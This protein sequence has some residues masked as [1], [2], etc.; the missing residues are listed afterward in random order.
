MNY[1]LQLTTAIGALSALAMAM[2]SLAQE[3]Y[4]EIIVTAQKKSES[5]QSV[6]ISVT[7]FSG[8]DIREGGITT[9]VGIA[10]QTP[11][12]NIGTPVGEGNNPSITLRGIGLN[13]F[14]DNNEGPVSVYNDGVYVAALPAQTFQLFDL[15]RVEVL[16]GPQG[17]LFGRNA[18]GGLIQFV[19]KKPT[20]EFE[21]FTSIT[22]GSFSQLK[23]ESAIG[24]SILDGVQGRLS[25]ASNRQDAY[26]ENTLGS[27]GNESDNFAARGQLNFDIK[28]RGSILLRGDYAQND[29]SAGR[30]AQEP[31]GSFFNEVFPDQLV[32]QFGFADTDG[33]PFTVTQDRAG[34]E[35]EVETYTFSGTVDY[36]L[37]D[38]ISITSITSYSETD[39]LYEEDTDA[40]PT[41]GINAD[42]DSSSDQFSQE[43]RFSGDHGKFSWQGGGFY[44]NSTVTNDQSVVVNQTLEF[45]DFLDDLPGADGGFE[46][47][48]SGLL[49][50]GTPFID[51]GLF[52]FGGAQFIDPSRNPIAVD[53]SLVNVPI[54]GDF[55]PFITFDV[56]YEQDTESFA[57]FYQFDYDFTDDLTLT[58]GIR[59]TN[60]SRDIQ[61]LNAAPAGPLLNDFFA[62]PGLVDDT[63]PDLSL[64]EAFGSTAGNFFDFTDEG[65]AARGLDTDLN[66]IDDD[67]VTGRAVIEYQA[68][69]TSL[70]YASYNRGFK[71]AGFNT[72]FLDSS[73]GVTVDQVVYD[74]ETL[75]AY[76]FGVKNTFFDGRFRLNAS[77]F[78]YDY[79]DFQA[80]TFQGLS[81]FITN[82]DATFFG[83]EVE[84]SAYLA[85]G[86]EA[87]LGISLLDTDVD[88][89]QDNNAGTVINDVEAV[90]A[91]NFSIN[92][93][94]SYEKPAFGGKL[95]GTVDFSYQGS[96]FFDI[97][98]SD[99]SNEDAYGLVNLR[100]AY[101]VGDNDQYELAG[102]VN[103]VADTEYR[104]YTFDFSGVAGLNQ[105]F[106]GPPRWFGASATY[107]FK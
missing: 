7:A 83:G 63:L 56:N 89:V 46:G 1:R 95:K 47:G 87:N 19:S 22:V 57:A 67:A 69:D 79:N 85:E 24:G 6:P 12:L 16:R 49:N 88:G 74:S 96:Q 32:D 25:I 3:S 75:N 48:L 72:G 44:F 98:N 93:A 2:P 38:S 92:G 66:N 31:T 73:D 65:L 27:D 71:S 100:L 70:V 55:L 33:D 4:D 104:V 34:N 8:D 36:D 35:L 64:F 90:L 30:I 59:Y 20:E 103:N 40:G 78:Y 97:T 15:E 42:F 5:L 80:L 39:R 105:Q 86:L 11:G 81:Q 10:A 23:T 53:P 106:F 91:P 9:S 68:T 26:V 51:G 21:A 84:A 94:L 29:V 54:S 43:I 13:D 37:T 82:A 17:T 14:N 28:E 101:T 77:A 62:I 61:Y 60:D 18:T 107:K 76:E 45:V 52:D 41:P 50:G 99:I 102:F 58:G